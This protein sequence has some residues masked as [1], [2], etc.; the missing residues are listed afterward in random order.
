MTVIVYRKERGSMPTRYEE[1]QVVL[2]QD[3]KRFYVITTGRDYYFDF[4]G[5]Y[6]KTEED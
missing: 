5:F 4:D 2:S 3:N 6:Y 1:A